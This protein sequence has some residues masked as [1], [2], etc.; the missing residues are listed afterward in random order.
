MGTYNNS[1]NNYRNNIFNGNNKGDNAMMN[2]R[3]YNKFENF[4]VTNSAPRCP[5]TLL[6][7]TSG[8]MDGQPI[9]E[10]NA[11][12]RQ[13][14][15]DLKQDEVASCSVE[16]EIIRFDSQAQIVTPYT[17]IQDLNNVPTLYADGWTSMGAGLSLATNE[18]KSR[19]RLYKQNG[20]AAYK[21][22]VVLMTD[23]GPN[24]NWQQAAAAMRELGEQKK[25]WYMGVEIGPF[26]DHNTMCQIMP[27]NSPPLKL[28]GLRFRDFFKWLSDSLKSVSSSAVSEEDNV[29]FAYPDW[30]DLSGM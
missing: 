22:W 18:L 6:V 30:A 15:E 2:N 10:L 1:N 8:S 13:F 7:D 20:C 28:D 23:G 19:R 16:L 26:A 21:P 25:I 11:A 29:Q 3:R 24:D 12:I 27:L 17:A 5:V 4:D 14:V 9:N